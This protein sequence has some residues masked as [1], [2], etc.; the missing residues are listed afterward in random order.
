MK[1]II[2]L[3]TLVTLL[4]L[5]SGIGYYLFFIEF[6]PHIYPDNSYTGSVSSEYTFPFKDS[7]IT[8]SIL[9][10]ESTY[11]GAVDAGSKQ[12]PNVKVDNFVC[13]ADLTN[14]P[15]Q[16]DMYTQILDQTETLKN[17]LN[18]TDD[19]YVEL[20]ST[21]VQS[22]QYRT[23]EVFRYPVE[24]IIE[25]YGDCDDK[26]TLL[27]GLLTRADYDAVLLIFDEESHATVGIKTTDMTAYPNTGGYAV[28]ETTGYSYITDRSFRFENGSSLKSTP[29][30]VDVGTGIK[31]YNSGYQVTAILNY[32]D[33]A[34]SQV[35]LLSIE[36][37]AHTKK[38]EGMENT[39]TQYEARLTSLESSMKTALAEYNSYI[40]RANRVTSQ[41]KKLNNDV[42]AK[43]ITYAEYSSAWDMLKTKC[44]EAVRKA[45]EASN[46]YNTYYT[47]YETLYVE[48]QPYF[49]TYT[50]AY[51][52]YS[53]KVDEENRYADIYNLIISEPYN[54]QYVYQTVMCAA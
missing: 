21:F 30:V 35:D 1:K 54:R 33:K 20:L 13:Y 43:K 3:V 49:S 47:Q 27:A 18:L 23:K 38:L 17:S 5:S 15:L 12:L 37:A 14:D 40:D 36:S 53:S 4:I 9:I 45:K 39:I 51:D 10:P 28:I 50:N 42:D 31:T 26:S 22:I 24:T 41:Q 32:R 25:K 44:E 19:E 48:Y 16:E 34:E 2:I 11:H 46:E 7:S 29:T 8:L 52:D 6:N